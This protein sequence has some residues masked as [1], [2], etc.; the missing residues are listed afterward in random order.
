[1]R[2]LLDTNVLSEIMRKLPDGRVLRWF[3]SLDRVLISVVSLEELVFGLR[4]RSLLKKEAWLRQML[5]DKGSLLPVTVLATLWCGE[6]RA[7][8]EASGRIVT[9]ADAL[10]AACAWEEGLILA[11]RNVK[12]FEGF[13]IPLLNPFEA[14]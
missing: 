2:Y 14:G 13:G 1:M 12:D 6:K 11:T 10:I 3:G 9:Q 8:L 5:A 7:E 4:R